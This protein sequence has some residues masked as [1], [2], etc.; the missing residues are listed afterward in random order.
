MKIAIQ[1]VGGFPQSGVT[2]HVNNVV[3]SLTDNTANCQW[4]ILDAD[5]NITAGP[6]RNILSSGQMNLWVGDNVYV[7]L[8]VAANIGVMPIAT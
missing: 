2:L 4:T 8:C 3:V 1:P 7:P 5:G 6:A